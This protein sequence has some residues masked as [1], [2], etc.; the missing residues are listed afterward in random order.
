MSPRCSATARR[1][2]RAQVARQVRRASSTTVC[3]HQDAPARRCRCCELLV[4]D[5]ATEVRQ[6]LARAVAPA[7]G[8]PL[9]VARQLADDEIE[10]AR[11]I[12]EHSPVLGDED[13][14][15]VVRTNAMQYALAVAGRERLSELGSRGAGRH[16]PRGG[17][18][19]AGRQCAVRAISQGTLQRVIQ[20]F[21][22]DD[23]IHTRPSGGRHCRYEVVEQLIGVLGD[24]L[25]WSAGSRPAAASRRGARA[26]RRGAGAGGD[27]LHRAR[28]CRRQAA[29]ASARP[30]WRR[31]PWVT[32]SCWLSCATARS[33]AWRSAWRCMPASISTRCGNCS[34]MPIAAIWRHY[35]SR[36]VSPR[37]TTSPCAWLW[38]SPRRR[39]APKTSPSGYN[40]ETIRFL[41]LQYERLRLDE[42]KLRL[43]LGN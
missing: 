17:R 42:A 12:L 38:R 43:L 18:P 27:Q 31:P 1:S 41:Q 16:G 28:P 14:V 21:S 30:S 24:R 6:A 34:T 11:P 37:H 5:L 7:H 25:E 26:D 15:R 29:A 10:I 33:R 2:A 20:D 32:S 39:P 35:A 13:L 40:P 4:R 9:E 36:P 23:Q 8:L 3:R 22:G 19:P